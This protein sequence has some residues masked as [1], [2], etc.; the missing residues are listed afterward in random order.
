LRAALDGAGPLGEVQKVYWQTIG[1]QPPATPPSGGSPSS[2]PH[3][4]PASS[5]ARL[6]VGVPVA[7][8]GG[9]AVVLAGVLLLHHRRQRRQRRTLWGRAL[10][11]GAAPGTSL[12][13]TDIVDSTR[14]WE[15]VPSIAMSRA[16]QMHHDTLRSLL[17]SYN[18]YESATEGDAFILSFYTT[19]DAVAYALK[20]QA[21]L[22]HQPWP[23]ELCE[24]E[25]CRPLYVMARP[26]CGVSSER[27]RGSGLPRSGLLPLPLPLPLPGPR[28][29]G[30]P[31]PGLGL[32][33]GDLPGPLQQL[34]L[35]L[36]SLASGGGGSGGGGMLGSPLRGAASGDVGLSSSQLNSGGGGGGGVSSRHARV[37][38][39]GSAS[40]G[41]H[42]GAEEQQSAAAAAA[43]GQLYGDSGSRPPSSPLPSLAPPHWLSSAVLSASFRSLR[44]NTSSRTPDGGGGGGG[45]GPLTTPAA[46]LLRRQPST[47]L[48]Q[49][50]AV[51]LPAPPGAL[52]LQTA[53]SLPH[54]SSPLGRRAPQVQNSAQPQPPPQPQPQSSQ[55]QSSHSAPIQFH[56][57]QQQQTVRSYIRH[58][59]TFFRDRTASAAAEA[60][61]AATPQQQ[62]QREDLVVV[63]NE[64]DTV[65]LSTCSRQAYGNNGTEGEQRDISS[66]LPHASTSANPVLDGGGGDG[67]GGG[68]ASSSVPL[69]IA[70]RHATATTAP[71]ADP[72]PT[73]LI[74]PSTA[75]SPCTSPRFTA[76]LTDTVSSGE[77]VTV[78]EAAAQLAASNEAALTTTTVSLPAPLPL[79]HSTG[80]RL[81]FVDTNPVLMGL[82]SSDVSFS[83]TVV[84]EITVATATVTAAGTAVGATAA[85]SS[86]SGGGTSPPASG[87]GLWGS[88]AQLQRRL[89]PPLS[90]LGTSLGA[91]G[92][93]GATGSRVS[94]EAP[95]SGGGGGGTA[96]SGNGGGFLTSSGGGGGYYT[97]A[98]AAAAV[99]GAVRTLTLG[100][101]FQQLYRPCAVGEEPPPGSVLVFG[102]L[103]VRMGIH[104]GVAAGQVSYNKVA[105]R[106]QYSGAVLE[107]AKAVGDAA[108]GGMVLLSEAAFDQLVRPTET[109][110][111]RGLGGG[112]LHLG[113][114]GGGGGGGSRD[115][116]QV[117][118]LHMG[119]HLLKS[120]PEAVTLYMAQSRDLLPRMA[121]LCPS[122]SSAAAAAAAATTGA[123]NAPGL[124]PASPPAAA[125]V[126]PVRS[127]CELERG[128]LHAPLGEVA[129]AVLMVVGLPTLLAWNKE[130]TEAALA[131]FRSVVVATALR[132]LG[133]HLVEVE[134]GR[135]VAAFRHPYEAVR[136][137]AACAALLK[138]A[139]WS[140]A[141]LSHELAE[142][143]TGSV[144]MDSLSMV[145]E[146]GGPADEGDDNEPT[147]LLFRGLRVKGAVDVGPT[148][149][150]L[151]PATGRPAYR[152][153][154][155]ANVQRIAAYVSTGQVVC[156]S[157][158][159][160]GYESAVALAAAL[161][162][163]GCEV[164]GAE[165]AATPLVGAP[166][167]PHCIRGVGDKVELWSVR[168]A[169]EF[170]CAAAAAAA[171]E[172][173]EAA[174]AIA[175]GSGGGGGGGGESVVDEISFYMMSEQQLLVVVVLLRSGW[176][177]V[178]R[179]CCRG[180]RGCGR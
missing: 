178:W 130:V 2:S 129:M 97:A 93:A 12:V 118:L 18:G 74:P 99:A 155:A 65:S 136:W 165:E 77:P 55:I 10:A 25:P 109:A 152:G 104:A 91:T 94:S 110:G 62:Q 36:T 66:C 9:V 171:V 151:L 42:A 48:P 23:L 64:S 134:A 13:V 57:R 126:S 102:G 40:P 169:E 140:E 85:A 24:E 139:E 45:G 7:A 11:P 20:A 175:G 67:G 153:P 100:A 128:A 157:P 176:A 107:G 145:P 164:L 89:T 54:G 49:V 133:G 168:L 53:M 148:R 88:L 86:G 132:Q 6:D 172:A 179:S 113:G 121:L 177:A 150:E 124:L 180:L 1:Y 84:T 162:A 114:G 108:Q 135:V 167:G 60:E 22:L 147:R 161:G 72:V 69:S 123:T 44:R 92:G 15:T 131:T 26:L 174:A 39:G 35:G 27:P 149:A 112:L 125:D 79:L 141:L 137:A 166:L 143:V 156:T 43:A 56:A 115:A 8:V 80:S 160:H 120:G 21:A 101:Y 82:D 75:I 59:R 159:W 95:N 37:L 5:G 19:A 142:E 90:A 38:R 61:A 116:L 106:T 154:L 71:T 119:R 68:V 47:S 111:S 76:L 173:A 4:T 58:P 51:P 70:M 73:S 144:M 63:G 32:F 127:V 103:Q 41:L 3:P 83:G 16:V 81:R 30:G 117:L 105:G 78:A 31:S 146:H 52:Q 138:E 29:P 98:S 170:E 50:P 17:G 14:L 28:S 158:V 46:T 122:S 34:G 96:S 33:R 87:N 163:P